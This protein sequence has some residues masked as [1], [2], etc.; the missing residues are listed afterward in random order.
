MGLYVFPIRISHGER[1]RAYRANEGFLLSMGPFMICQGAFFFEC[2]P[3]SSTLVLCGSVWFHL[4]VLQDTQVLVSSVAYVT[5]EW[6]V[7]IIRRFQVRRVGLVCMFL[8]KLI[9]VKL[10]VASA[11]SGKLIPASTVRLNHIS[12]DIFVSQK[13]S[14]QS[15]GLTTFIAL[16]P[17]FHEKQ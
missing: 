4:M 2:T 5:W 11:A 10:F 9:C 16:E 8:Q 3:A 1:F 15:E 6:L 14:F 12:V 13:S 17:T 7:R